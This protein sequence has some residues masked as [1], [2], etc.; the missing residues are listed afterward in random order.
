VEAGELAR[1][2]KSFSECR[3]ADAQA[4]LSAADG[5]EALGAEDLELLARSAYMLGDDAEY[6]EHLERAHDR[7]REAGDVPRA[8]RCAFWSGHNLL[9]RGERVHAAGWFGRAQR[10]VDADA[11]DCVERGYLLIPRWLAQM[12][13]DDWQGG[14]ETAAAAAAIG[15][16]FGDRDLVW[17]ARDEQSRALLN[18][19]RVQEGLL[20]ADEVLIAAQ[21]LSPIV[22]GIVYCNTVAFCQSAYQVRHA[23]AWTEALNSWCER[24]PAMVAH[25]GLCLVHRAEVMR[26][27]GEWAGALE[28]VT[29]ATDRF[30]AGVL[31]ELACGRAHYER[32]EVYR[33]RG[34]FSQA[35]AAYRAASRCGHEPQPGLALLRLGTGDAAAAAA[36]IRRAIGETTKPL[37]RARLLPAYV[38]IMLAT[39]ELERARG[40]C[41]ELEQLAGIHPSEALRAMADQAEGSARLNAGE[42]E[43][44]LPTLRAAAAGWRSLGARHEA[45]R[46]RELLGRACRDVGD[47]DSAALEFEAALEDFVALGAAPDAERVRA[48]LA[49]TAGAPDAHGLSQR[50][51]EVLRL[52]AAGN[53]NRDIAATLVISE[54]TVARHLQ[55]IYGKLGV[56]TRTAAGAFAYEHHLI[57]PN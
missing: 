8:A 9:F 35:E 39:A 15:E 26:L 20:L 22:A 45:A 21:E 40:A 47:E 38:E 36:A 18:L 30:T 41:A 19:G 13:G 29:R 31:N 2:R 53:S 54:H 3:W 25:M 27:H 14:L 42:P 51:L 12:A 56:S 28:E 50:E 1:G 55:N 17:L 6:R 33:L 57:G 37:Q 10:L 49:P 32:G 23:Q 52:L 48:L 43:A 4:A 24:Q 44:A 11:R 46:A 5:Q 34:A 7:H 16:R